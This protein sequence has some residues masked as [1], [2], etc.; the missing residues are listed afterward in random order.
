MDA[1]LPLASTDRVLL[2]SPH[3]DD[4]SLAAGGLLQRAHINGAAIRI[5]YLTDGDN[6]PWAQRA[7][8]RRIWIGARDRARFA[9]RR[10]DEVANALSALGLARDS[11]EF[12]A[13]PDQGLTGLLL[14]GSEHVVPQLQHDI[15]MWRPTLIVGPS[16]RDRHPD[17][18]ALAVLLEL[19]IAGI[20]GGD[21]HPRRLRFVIHNTSLRNDLLPACS[22]QLTDDELAVKLAAVNC[23]RSQHFWRHTWLLGFARAGERYFGEEPSAEASDHPIRAVEW[24][25]DACCLTLV[26]KHRV[27]AFGQRTLYL[28][29]QTESRAYR[30]AIDLSIGRRRISVF[31]LDTR[32]EVGPAQLSGTV[33]HGTLVLPA[34]LLAAAGV[35]FA[36]L[37][38]RFG[39]FDEA[40]WIE[41]AK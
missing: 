17:H 15:E 3:P 20:R 35:A 18:S 12:L 21:P 38:H 5:V 7:V 19:A 23:H 22:L 39:F 11:A 29:G 41:V 6:N 24:R 2:F 37:E 13:F 1:T 25:N 16:L 30:Y 33:R 4:E 40:G 14:R 9:V 10:R 31:D 34:G 8:E 26:S 32:T 27:R 28:V 36:K